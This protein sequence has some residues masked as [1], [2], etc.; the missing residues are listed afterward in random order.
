[1]KINKLFL[2]PILLLS[3]V[4]NNLPQ[5][6][7]L[8]P[9]PSI[10]SSS[11]STVISSSPT[12]LPTPTITPKP[13]INNTEKKFKIGLSNTFYRITNSKSPDKVLDKKNTILIINDLLVDGIIIDFNQNIV[14]KNLDGD[15]EDDNGEFPLYNEII[16]ELGN[17]NVFF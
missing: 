7:I 11:Q 17:K 1:M 13:I 3:C 10:S 9:I 2:I 8:S 6:N 5:N 4:N 15:I 12:L 14:D 16:E